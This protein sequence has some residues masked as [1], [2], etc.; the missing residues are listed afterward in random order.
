MKGFKNPFKKKVY[1]AIG[2]YELGKIYPEHEV[3]AQR[4]KVTTLKNQVS[5]Y[6]GKIEDLG[7][8]DLITDLPRLSS[9]ELSEWRTA[10]DNV[11]RFKRQLEAEAPILKVME[12]SRA[13]PQLQPTFADI[14]KRAKS[15]KNYPS[16]IIDAMDKELFT[17]SKL[18]F[19]PKHIIEEAKRLRELTAKFKF[20]DAALEKLYPKWLDKAIEEETK[21]DGTDAVR[22]L[23]NKRIQNWK[24]KVKVIKENEK[25]YMLD[26]VKDHIGHSTAKFSREFIKKINAGSYKTDSDVKRIEAKNEVLK[27]AAQASAP[28][29]I[30]SPMTSVVKTSSGISLPTSGASML[31]G[32]WDDY[33]E[34]EQMGFFSIKIGNPFKAIENAFK[35]VQ[36]EVE[37]A[38]SVVVNNTVGSSLAKDIIPKQL[39]GPIS[40]LSKASIKIMSGKISPEIVGD[41]LE[42]IY[43]QG[44]YFSQGA[45]W[46]IDETNKVILSS[47]VGR[48]LD[49][50]TGGII[51]SVGRIADLDNAVLEDRKV[52]PVQIV[53]DVAKIVAVVASA[54]SAG[55]LVSTM[56]Q[57]VAT[58]YVGQQ[59]GLS[60]TALGQSLLAAASGGGSM[61]DIATKTATSYATSEGTKQATKALTPMLG[62]DGATILGT[63]V[64]TS[65]VS[66]ASGSNKSFTD[67]FTQS[68]SQSTKTLAT[69]KASEE[70]ARALTPMLGKDASN[71]VGMA[72]GSSAVEQATGTKQTFAQQVQSRTVASAKSFAMTKADEEVKRITGGVIGLSEAKK[73]YDLDPSEI[74]KENAKKLIDIEVMKAKKRMEAERQKAMNVSERIKYEYDLAKAKVTDPQA[75]EKLQ[76]HTQEQI[77]NETT[78]LETKYKQIQSEMDKVLNSKG[79]DFNMSDEMNKVK[80]DLAENYQ[81]EK[82]KF[83]SMTS[84]D[85]FDLAKQYGPHLLKYLMYKYGPKPNYDKY[86]TENDLQSYQNWTPQPTI[87]P[88]KKSKMPWMIAGV[89]AVGAYIALKD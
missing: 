78:K 87:Y 31:A 48:D 19:Y 52:N 62:K 64:A 71:I 25:T 32:I 45:T 42:A 80:T 89:T 68:A 46:I 81:R 35:N 3:M 61:T 82:E 24:E 63:A 12:L 57:T 37:K 76:A 33:L 29:S 40:K 39:Y 18:P 13:L 1:N 43:K 16:K 47:P 72:V 67:T 88:P 84:D 85:V 17:D 6:Q 70:T 8:H 50:Y 11:Q 10:R 86:V 49:K 28:T 22:Q 26:S 60:K 7:V 14:L 15:K 23:V 79:S 69:Q 65:T 27:T 51:S 56:S 53:M 4:Q 38:L 66:S 74:S 20:A 30:S 83:L 21:K 59:T 54:G 75:L 36:R 9:V 34:E 44:A 5:F 2:F 41:A 77:N 58:N 55:A 73:I